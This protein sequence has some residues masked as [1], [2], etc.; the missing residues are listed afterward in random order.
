MKIP[1]GLHWNRLRPRLRGRAFTFARRLLA[2]ALLVTA[3]V[4][5]TRPS[6]T[7]PALPRP[8]RTEGPPSAALPAAPGFSTVPVRLADAGVA[9]LLTRGT[10]VDLVTLEAG[11][12][13]RRVLVSMATVVDVRSPP[14]AGSR[15]LAA[16]NKGPLVLI[17]VPA[18]LAPQVA[19]LALRNPV[20]VTLR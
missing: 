13:N 17:A 10:R 20:A 19:A 6:P 12:Q 9:E 2:A 7:G 14:P 11:E 16:E 8:A 5:L 18:E 15:L 4:L 1:S 3:A